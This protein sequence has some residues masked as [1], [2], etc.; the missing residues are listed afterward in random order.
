MKLHAVFL[1]QVPHDFD[2]LDQTLLTLVLAVGSFLGECFNSI[3]N[4]VLQFFGQVNRCE[5]TLTY[6]LDRLELFVKSSLV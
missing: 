5:V 2:F 1:V 3:G 4:F 6:L